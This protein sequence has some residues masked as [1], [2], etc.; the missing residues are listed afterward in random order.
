MWTAFWAPAGCRPRNVKYFSAKKYGQ[1]IFFN[2]FWGVLH[3]DTE[4]SS[5]L[6]YAGF[7]QTH[8]KQYQKIWYPLSLVIL[9]PHIHFYGLFLFF[10][11][12]PT[13]D[14]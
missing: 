4:N 2:V 11:G 10:F 9:T 7:V 3:L 12:H 8:S 5:I 13:A 1:S 6:I 14:C